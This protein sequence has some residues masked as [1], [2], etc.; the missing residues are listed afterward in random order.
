MVSVYTRWRLMQTR[1]AVFIAANASGSR[2]YVAVH[3]HELLPQLIEKAVAAQALITRIRPTV[4]IFTAVVA[5]D[6]AASVAVLL[7]STRRAR[8][9]TRRDGIGSYVLRKGK[10]A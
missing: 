10:R 1:P 4:G 8:L 2:L 7:G 6:R 9:G 5:G 3:S